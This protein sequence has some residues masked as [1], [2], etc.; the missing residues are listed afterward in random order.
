MA[1]IIAKAP[2][3]ARASKTAATVNEAAPIVAAQAKPF[4]ERMAET[5]LRAVS[6][7]KQVRKEERDAF[8]AICHEAK[9]MS[10][11]DFDKLYRVAFS[12]ALLK[13]GAT[14]LFA[15]QAVSFYAN[16]MVAVCN[17]FKVP[18][19]SYSIQLISRSEACVNFL[20]EKKLKKAKAKREQSERGEKAQK[21]QDAK[22]AKAVLD[23][24]DALEAFAMAWG[25]RI[26]NGDKKA[27]EFNGMML[28]TLLSAA[29]NAPDMLVAALES[30]GYDVDAISE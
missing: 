16:V 4:A 15:G 27:A 9:C 29:D 12:D 10:F 13:G 28:Y 21:A 23:T 22:Q 3:K 5:C 7:S 8:L 11:A 20:V 25:R 1:S 17:G 26:A 24:D 6:A 14:K 30:G 18:D 2:A 19:E